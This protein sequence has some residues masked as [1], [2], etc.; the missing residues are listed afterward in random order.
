MKR[1]SLKICLRK[2]LGE[3]SVRLNFNFVQ[4]NNS[5]ATIIGHFSFEMRFDRSWSINLPFK[6]SK[7]IV[8]FVFLQGGSL[9]RHY[10]I[11]DK[12]SKHFLNLFNI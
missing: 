3:Y 1:R 5:L 6:F 9:R 10:Q 11:K 7:F 12:V 8:R 4:E 2:K